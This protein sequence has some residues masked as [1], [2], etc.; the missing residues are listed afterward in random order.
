MAQDLKVIGCMCSAK[1]DYSLAWLL[2]DSI[3]KFYED[4]ENV[5]AFQE[6]EK[7]YD[8]KKKGA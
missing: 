7:R 3:E 4:P 1:P 2:R 6:W 5:K 8:E